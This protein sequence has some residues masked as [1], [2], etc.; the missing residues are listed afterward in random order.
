MTTQ[1]ILEKLL[2][3]ERALLQRDCLAAHT[4][5]MEAQDQLLRLEREMIER[6]A[7]KVRQAADGR[8]AAV[9]AAVISDWSGRAHALVSDADPEGDGM[10]ALLQALGRS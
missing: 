1:T 8:D 2:E 3:I 9:P 4:H 7:E 5:L 10:E 6:Q